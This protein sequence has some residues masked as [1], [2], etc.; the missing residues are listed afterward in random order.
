M[1]REDCFCSKMKSKNYATVKSLAKNTIQLNLHELLNGYFYHYK[2]GK[3]LFNLPIEEKMTEIARVTSLIGGNKQELIYDFLINN[4]AENYLLKNFI[5]KE[6]KFVYSPKSNF[7]KEL[8]ELRN[9]IYNQIR[10]RKWD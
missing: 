3:C 8:S 7:N 1:N 5:Y 9:Y 6:D 2:V 4:K 10:R